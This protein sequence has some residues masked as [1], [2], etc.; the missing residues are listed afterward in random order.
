MAFLNRLRPA[1]RRAARS[2]AARLAPAGLTEGL[3][4][5]LLGIDGVEL[6]RI[7]D[8]L[9]QA[10][11]PCL[12]GGGWGIDLLAGAQTRR[13]IDI[14]IVVDSDPR[15]MSRACDALAAVGYEV[16]DECAAGGP[17]MPIA[18]VVRD[19][20]GHTIELLAVDEPFAGTTGTFEGR[21]IA[22]LTPEAQLR[23][24][25][26]FEPRP[27]DRHD[28]AVL[29]QRFGLAAPPGYET[30]S[31]PVSAHWRQLLRRVRPAR[32]S[33]LII[34]VAEAEPA[35]GG[36]RR[37]HDPAA[38]HGLPAHVTVL[39]PFLP[40]RALDVHVLQRLGDLAASAPAFGFEFRDFGRF[41]GVLY[42]APQPAD[43]FVAL[44][45]AVGARWPTCPPYGGAFDRIIPHLT[46][47]EGAAAEVGPAMAAVAQALPIAARAA[48]LWLM[49]QDEASRWQV[50]ERFPL[51]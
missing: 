51:G 36:W 48:E 31:S 14:D 24:H 19:E 39:Y 5:R 3:R 27:I 1:M 49:V 28:V 8:V 17:L 50:R 6:V 44:T 15:T 13:H 22:C 9:E 7:I 18:V 42:L 11:V 40:A 30:P 38:H 16:T 37:L 41:P 26:G 4:R 34:P 25:E 46:V 45:E 21:E 20:V 10:G 23:L 29:C 35:V 47:A 2:P 43:P 32:E 12:V 33:A